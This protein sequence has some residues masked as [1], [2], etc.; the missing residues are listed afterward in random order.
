MRKLHWTQKQQNK[1]LSFGLNRNVKAFEKIVRRLA[2]QSYKQ[3]IK[4][5]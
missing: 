5:D 1:N 3:T 4:D 2:A